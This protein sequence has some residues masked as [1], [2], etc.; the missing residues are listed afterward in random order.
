[1]MQQMLWP[2]LCVMLLRERDLRTPDSGKGAGLS[3]SFHKYG[4]VCGQRD[5]MSLYIGEEERQRN[6]SRPARHPPGGWG[7]WVISVSLVVG[8]FRTSPPPRSLTTFSSIRKKPRK[9]SYW[10]W[11]SK[12]GL[13]I[14]KPRDILLPSTPPWRILKRLERGWTWPESRLSLPP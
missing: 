13:R 9:N 12:P 6:R 1:M 3:A 4:E 7:L 11:P 2:S 8:D 14:C 5:A 10:K